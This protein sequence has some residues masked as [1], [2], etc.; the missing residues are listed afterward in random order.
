M[1]R[2]RLVLL[3]AIAAAVLLFFALGLGRYFTL[4]FVQSQQAALAA[5][6]GANPLRTAALFFLIYVALA[7]LS[8]PGAVVLTIAAGA[9]FGLV[10][11]LILVS[12]A[13]SIGA[14][15]AF[16]TS[17]FLLRDAIRALQRANTQ[18]RL[19]TPAKPA[20]APA[21]AKAPEA[22]ATPPAEPKPSDPAHHVEAQTADS[23]S[24]SARLATHANAADDILAAARARIQQRSSGPGSH[25][26]HGTHADPDIAPAPT[27]H[28]PPPAYQ[29]EEAP[30]ASEP[31]QETS[32][33][34]EEL[35]AV[36]TA[37][38]AES[39]PGSAQEPAGA[40]GPRQSWTPP[41]DMRPQP[42]AR[43]PQAPAGRAP[44]PRGPR[45]EDGQRQPPR[46]RPGT[47]PGPMP[48]S[49]PVAGLPNRPARAPWPEPGEH[50]GQ[51]RP[52]AANGSFAGP[53]YA[54]AGG[55]LPG[56][57]QSPRSAPAQR[58]GSQPD[59]GPLVESVPR[60]MRVGV[61]S[62]AEVRISRDRIEALVVALNG[63]GMPHRPDQFL[64][65][66]LS[67]RLKAPNGGFF[68]EPASPETQW[69]ER[70]STHARDEHAI[71]RWTVTPQRRGRGRLLLMV[72]ARTVG[73]DGLP[74]ESAPPDR[75][76]EVRV[77]PNRM[78]GL[79]RWLA[80]LTALAIGAALGR[81]SDQLW[82][83]ASALIKK[84]LDG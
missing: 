15:L 20:G 1:N 34:F 77:S 69:V 42:N 13:S 3:V 81:F 53:H 68:I 58:S 2:R 19:K 26:S 25:A 51:A 75:L 14:T 21:A 11:G 9:I 79:G 55:P 38:R 30:M 44:P 66:A 70:T 8:V 10:V 50:N 32:N 71:W 7:A 60:R 67:V 74:A 35:L 24:L 4:E 29:A 47:A 49:M 36:S 46:A 63:H 64:A 28:E 84:M 72:S 39:D 82:T 65:R 16:L 27:S 12:F 45:P 37:A 73:H 56:P 43:H 17:R 80:W 76:I 59:R 48:G 6:Y 52:Q 78:R 41:P 33:A 18:A 23:A 5:Y 83:T 40:R 57:S 61:A 22:A 31:P 62:K 54:D